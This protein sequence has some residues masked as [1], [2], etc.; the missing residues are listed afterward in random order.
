M[1]INEKVFCKKNLYSKGIY[2]MSGTVYKK[3]TYY[4][5]SYI[6]NGYIFIPYSDATDFSYNCFHESNDIDIR[7]EFEYLD[8]EPYIF[9]D[10]FD[11]EQQIRRNKLKKIINYNQ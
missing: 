6:E 9:N 2:G 11:T 3:G 5:I 1:K 8:N 7:Y 4:R 10:Y